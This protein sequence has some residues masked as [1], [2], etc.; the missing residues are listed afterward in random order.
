[1]QLKRFEGLDVVRTLLA[2][3]VALGHFFIWNGVLTVIPISFFLAVDFFFVLSGF[4]LTQSVLHDSHRKFIPF[5]KHFFLRRVFR[6]YPLYILVFVL[7]CVEQVY[8]YGWPSDKLYYFLLSFFLLHAM[9]PE[10]NAVN[11]YSAT[12]IGIA[13]SISVEL[14]AGLIFFSV[15]FLLREYRRLLIAACLITV[16]VTLYLM[17]KYSPIKM[18]VNLQRYNGIA[19]FG[20]IRGFMGFALGYL[21]YVIYQQLNKINWRNP[22]IFTIAEVLILSAIAFMYVHIGVG[23]Y[24]TDYEFAGPVM[25][26]LVVIV[27]ASGH[28]Y[29]SRLLYREELH[30][31]RNISFAVYLVH[32]FYIMIY[33]AFTLPFTVLSAIPYIMMIIATSFPLYLFIEKKGIEIGRRFHK[34][35]RPSREERL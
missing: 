25:A 21:G 11:L 28:G 27:I 26:M 1:M 15:V 8:H 22:V 14:W 30:S 33:K 35:S 18:N 16:A 34:K 10:S 31:L 7:T 5:L 23:T 24:N 3:L 20:E 29:L 6:L 12:S 19:T 4:V 2:V 17:V 32:P 13:W 9:G